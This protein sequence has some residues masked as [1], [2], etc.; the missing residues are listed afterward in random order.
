MDRRN[1]DEAVQAAHKHFYKFKATAST[2][3]VISY[4]PQ[5]FYI[6][7]SFQNEKKTFEIGKNVRKLKIRDSVSLR[8]QQIVHKMICF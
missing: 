7:I 8:S 4:S 5:C 2:L 3:A 6:Q 1:G